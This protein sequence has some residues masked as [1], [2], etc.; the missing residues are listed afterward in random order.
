MW[1]GTA[2]AP[3]SATGSLYCCWNL[4]YSNC[5]DWNCDWSLARGCHCRH[6]V[7]HS[8]ADRSGGGDGVRG[9][10][11]YYAG[12]YLSVEPRPRLSKRSVDNLYRLQPI[13]HLE[14]REGE[15]EKGERIKK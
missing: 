13:A 14:G 9:V 3:V 11:C 5:R 2:T 12:P 8:S 1:S 10:Y 7:H 6:F 4:N 15:R